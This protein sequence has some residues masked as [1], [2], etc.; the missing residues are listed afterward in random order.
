V[1][2]HYYGFDDHFDRDDPHST[3]FG[4]DAWAFFS[5]ITKSFREEY[6]ALLIWNSLKDFEI[7]EKNA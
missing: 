3:H 1:V 7:K 5:L 6:S 4:R 2:V